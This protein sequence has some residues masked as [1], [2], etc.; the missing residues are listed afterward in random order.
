MSMYKFVKGSRLF[1]QGKRESADYDNIHDTFAPAQ[2]EQDRARGGYR[3]EGP[4]ETASLP[5]FL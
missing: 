5:P 4:P 2:Y 1:V 3:I